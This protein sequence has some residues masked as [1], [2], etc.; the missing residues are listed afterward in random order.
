M[1]N[2]ILLKEIPGGKFHSAIFTTYSINLYYLEQKVLPLL[3]SKGIHYV[4]ILVDGGMLSSQL[5]NFSYLSQQ[6]K[7]KYAINGIQSNGAFHPK[8]IFLAGP[9]SVLLLVGSGNLTTSGHGKNLEVWNAVFI[10][11][12]DDAKYGFVIQAWNYLKHL[13]ADLG[14]SANNKLKSIEENCFLLS[15]IKNVEAAIFNLDEQNQISFHANQEDSSLFRQLSDIIGNDKIERITIMC[16]FHDSEGKFIQELNKRYKPSQIDV[17][18]QADFG[19]LPSKMTSQSNVSFYEW[20]EVMQEKQRQSYFHAK[21]IILDCKTKNYL[22]S[23][24]ANASL[25]AF[26]TITIPATNQ[27]SCVIYQSSDSDYLELLSLKIA[28]KPINLKDYESER[29]TNPKESS[30]L[31]RSVFIKSAEKNFDTVNLISHIKHPIKNGSIQLFDTKGTIQFE[32]MISLEPGD[33]FQQISISNGV[34]LLF[35]Q[36]SIQGKEASNKQFITDINAFESTNP[37]PRNRSLNQIRKLIESGNFST[38]K[39]I[40]YLNTIYRQK[41]A[42]KGIS[43]ASLQEERNDEL[44]L[45]EDDDLLYLSY[46]EIQEKAKKIDNQEKIHHYVEYKG[47]RLWESI[48]SYLKESREKELQY[49][50]DEEETEDINSSGGRFEKKESKPKRSISKSNFER[51]KDK[52]AKFLDSY[53][54]I[55]LQKT[56][57]PKSEQPSLIDLSMYLIML[58]ILLHLIGHKESIVEENKEKHLLQIPLSKKVYSWSDY[59]IQY[60]G[61]FT[62]WCRQK[63][64]LKDMDSTDY[65]IKLEH[66]KSMAFKTNLSALAIYNNVNKAYDYE[67]QNK[68]LILSLLNSNLVFNS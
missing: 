32:E 31:E 66:Y 63:N 45:E 29:K 56:I 37:S 7:R 27:E 38:P 3:G 67:L 13:H 24:S 20:T 6:R 16:P 58:E 17:L 19:S 40:D 47:V 5:E 21:N 48:F 54:E 11:S 26:G 22:I 35:V 9:D 68:W 33:H 25:A 15:N 61:M 65:R 1:K 39:I 59:L 30:E 8:L 14:E 60:I 52:V 55:L 28:S 53:Y 44:P 23:G 51:L 18:V 50:I 49:K 57:D 64:G 36:V 4:S 41:E 34:A 62:I 42:K 12:L 10:N 43:K 46:A 2:R